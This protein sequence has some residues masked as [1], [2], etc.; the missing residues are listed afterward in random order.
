MQEI[1]LVF[2]ENDA[3]PLCMQLRAA[4]DKQVHFLAHLADQSSHLCLEVREAWEDI[5][6]KAAKKWYVICHQLCACGTL[7]ECCCLQH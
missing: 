1:N 5:R 4:F 6:E 7:Q 3:R 2:A